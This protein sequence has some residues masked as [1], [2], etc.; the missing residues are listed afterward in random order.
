MDE[1]ERR[2]RKKLKILRRKKRRRRRML[3]LMLMTTVIFTILVA[4]GTMIMSFHSKQKAASD[5]DS[6]DIEV[7]TDSIDQTGSKS[8]MAA[9]R[10]VSLQLTDAQMHSGD[11]ILVSSER[12]YDFDANENMVRLVKITDAQTYNYPVDKEEFC[13]AESILPSLDSMIEDCDNA[14]GTRE[15]GISSAYR[16]KEYQQQV[17]DDAAE[18]YGES[19]AE[20]YVA[21]PG[22]SEHH[23]GLAADLG[24]FY[25]DGSYG[26]F[27][28]SENAI[29]MA[30]NCWKYGFVRRYA[31]DK[32]E[33]T[34]ISNEAWHFRY[35]GVP[36]AYYMT[37]NNLCLEEYLDYLER[38]ASEEAPLTI[39]ANDKSY[40]V[41]YTK[42]NVIP[43]PE[44]KFEVSG[45]NDHGWIITLCE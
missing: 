28:G 42:E 38:N 9:D 15:T 29:W 17:W 34:G 25:D 39:E 41:F 11:L 2:R 35:V 24:I 20:K 13:L 32:T 45:D 8:G 21:E 3:R 18:E 37:Q 40:R 36:H 14:M 19:Y 23:T 27:T 31:E 12:P 5:A 7:F 6:G 33:I 44:E 26:T 1:F 30:E 10:T 43:K 22:Y 4:A 16:T